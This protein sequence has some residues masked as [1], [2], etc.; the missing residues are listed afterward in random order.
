[1][2]LFVNRVAVFIAEEELSGLLETLRY[3]SDD[4][5]LEMQQ[6][7]QYLYHNYFSS[8]KAI[9]TTALDVINQ[10]V[11]PQNSK[12]YEDWNIPPHPVGIT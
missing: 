6:N 1:M 9:T 10:R 8:M 4:R 5:L 7:G 2:K 12:S 11:F 3:I